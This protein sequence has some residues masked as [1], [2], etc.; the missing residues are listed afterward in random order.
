[1]PKLEKNSCKIFMSWNVYWRSS[2]INW[3]IG[4]QKYRQIVMGP[5]CLS[6]SLN[7][8]FIHRQL[9]LFL[10]CPFFLLCR[11]IWVQKISFSRSRLLFEMWNH[12]MKYLSIIY[13]IKNYHS[14]FMSSF[15]YSFS[16]SLICFHSVSKLQNYYF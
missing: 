16:V 12:K 15:F 4:I 3:L 8:G 1:M 11:H 13:F 2:N 6:Q 9:L 10:I 7:L 14:S 5:I